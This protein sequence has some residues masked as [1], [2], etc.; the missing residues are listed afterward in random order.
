MFDVFNRMNV[1][2]SGLTAHRY[3]M[4]LISGNIANA[5][6]TSKPGS[7]YFH[8]QKPVFRT[9]LDEAG[10][11]A[12]VLVSKQT[13]DDSAP[14]IENIPGHPDADAEGNVTFSNV[15]VMTEMVDLIAASRGYEANAT[16]MEAAKSSF[17]RSIG[18][19][20]V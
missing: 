18:L 2:A 14:R 8:A 12:G 5:N 7:D 19:L 17:Q 1:A 4:D 13:T 11:V 9:M 10:K 16:V 3:W 6:T 15:N 20:Q